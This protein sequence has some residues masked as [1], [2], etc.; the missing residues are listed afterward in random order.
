MYYIE[1]TMVTLKSLYGYDFNWVTIMISEYAS[2]ARL[3]TI[4]TYAEAMICK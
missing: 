3:M 1:S 2:D 4:Y